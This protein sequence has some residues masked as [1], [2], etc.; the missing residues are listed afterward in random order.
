MSDA[1]AAPDWNAALY[2]QRFS[3]IAGYGRD[4]LPLL[5]PRA[6]ERILDLGCGTGRLTDEIASS[7]AEVVGV[8]SSPSMID[9]ARAHYPHLSFSVMDAREL[10]ADSPFDAVFSNAVLH[11]IPDPERVVR[12]VA[13]VLRPGGR[14]VLEMGGL[15]NIGA[16]RTAL[17]TAV[18]EIRSGHSESVDPWYF[19]GVGEYCSL[20]DRNGFRAIYALLFPRPTPLEGG[21]E[22]LATW[23][24]V[25]AKDV[26]A[27]LDEPERERVIARVEDR[28]RDA[29]FADGRWTADYVRL[30]VVAE[31]VDTE[32]RLP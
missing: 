22:G 16:I 20:L 15:G 9:E 24:Q 1:T 18:S 17:L 5:A 12:A 30:R 25:F 13:G 21:V 19:P 29:L 32:S 11:W 10:K 27:P 26:L 14:F 6:G 23:L 28:T 7:G 4:L 8:D 31:R 2:D 3:C